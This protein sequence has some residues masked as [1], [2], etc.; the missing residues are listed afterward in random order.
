MSTAKRCAPCFSLAPPRPA[1]PT[2]VWPLQVCG[3]YADTMAR[4]AQLI[5]DTCQVSFVDINFGCP[6]DLVCR[7]V[8]S[9]RLCCWLGCAGLCWAGWL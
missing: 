6:I 3:G 5:E 9:P 7:W 8:A 4:C 1:L 2:P